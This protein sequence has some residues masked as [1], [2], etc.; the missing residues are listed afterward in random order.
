MNQIACVDSQYIVP[1]VIY[2]EGKPRH[3][4]RV[5]SNEKGDVCVLSV[6]HL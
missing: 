5:Y 6:K 1:G 3:P 4:C 2:A